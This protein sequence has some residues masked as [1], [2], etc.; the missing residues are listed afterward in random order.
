[1]Q[2]RDAGFAPRLNGSTITLGPG[3][4]AMVGYGAYAAPA[5]SFGVQ[6]D[7]VIPS[8]IESVFA[9]FHLQAPRAL[10]ARFE[11]PM[12]GVLRV[13]V[14]PRSPG[15]L[16]LTAPVPRDPE[17][18]G[19]ISNPISFQATQ[20]GRPIPV[21]IENSGGSGAGLPWLVGELDVNDLTPGVPVEVRFHSDKFDPAE[22]EGSAYAIEY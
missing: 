9:D 10:E 21:R 1:V 17:K 13:I 5:Y 15:G 16:T 3:Q 18:S 6:E 20:S 22:L 12:H 7:V 2:F 11:P 14:R 8:S 19:I 4:M